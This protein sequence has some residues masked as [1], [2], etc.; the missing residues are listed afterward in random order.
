MATRYMERRT[1]SLFRK[2]KPPD[3]SGNKREE[4]QNQENNL[5]TFFS[6]EEQFENLER[7]WGNSFVFIL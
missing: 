6:L 1:K 3:R 7:I 2:A 4:K 5:V